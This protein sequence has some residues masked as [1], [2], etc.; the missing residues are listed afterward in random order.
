MDFETRVVEDPCSAVDPLFA[1]LDQRQITDGAGGWIAEVVGIHRDPRE[2]WVQIATSDA[3][4]ETV[5]LHLSPWAGT[6]D[7]LAALSAWSSCE[8]SR[9]PRIIEVMRLM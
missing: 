4:E 3:P 6:D 8:M 7:A 2:T 9:R 1:G 5:L